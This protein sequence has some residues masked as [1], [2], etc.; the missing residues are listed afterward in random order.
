M[1]ERFRQALLEDYRYKL[2]KT[3]LA[4]YA[5]L[6]EYSQ[7]LQLLRDVV[8]ALEESVSGQ[9]YRETIPTLERR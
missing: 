9:P 8:S 4:N 7:R 3:D 6:E 5:T 1:D 2:Q